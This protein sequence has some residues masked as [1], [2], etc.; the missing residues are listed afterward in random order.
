MTVTFIEGLP[1]LRY[2]EPQELNGLDSHSDRSAGDH[3]SSRKGATAKNQEWRGSCEVTSVPVMSPVMLTEAAMAALEPR[4]RETPS[5]RV[6]MSA[7][8]C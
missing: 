3:D 8:M 6:V 2:T 7:A 1:S 4:V 5:P